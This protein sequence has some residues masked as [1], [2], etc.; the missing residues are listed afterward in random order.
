[1]RQNAIAPA[2]LSPVDHPREV[3][4]TLAELMATH[5][6]VWITGPRA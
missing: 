3:D 5:P 6:A 4:A 2:V 1:M